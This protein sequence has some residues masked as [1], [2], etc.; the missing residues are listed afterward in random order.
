MKFNTFYY[1]HYLDSVSFSSIF[2]H[3]SSQIRI[4]SIFKKQQLSMLSFHYQVV[5]KHNI[6]RALLHTF[7][8]Q[9]AYYYALIWCI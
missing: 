9:T 4:Q 5:I 8:V 2:T 3:K 6:E 1:V 7:I